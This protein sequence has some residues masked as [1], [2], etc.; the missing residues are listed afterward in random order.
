MSVKIQIAGADFSSYI[1]SCD[2]ID[3]I[4]RNRDWSPIF[5]TFQMS[6]MKNIPSIPSEGDNIL[7]IV[8]DVI[9][10][11]GYLSRI[12]Y[13]EKN[14]TYECEVSHYLRKLQSLK[15]SYDDIHETLVGGIADFDS[16]EVFSVDTGND[17]IQNTA[18]GR[19]DGD[20]IQ[21][22][23]VGGILPAGILE[24]HIYWIRVVDA[25][26]FRIYEDFADYMAYTAD[27]SSLNRYVDITG[28]G[29]GT[30]TYTAAL[31]L[32]SYNDWCYFR[33]IRCI[34]NTITSE[35]RL[36]VFLKEGISTFPFL[37]SSDSFNIVMFD[38]EISSLPAPISKSRAY[39]AAAQTGVSDID[40]FTIYNDLTDLGSESPINYSGTPSSSRPH[41]CILIRKVG[42]SEEQKYPFPIVSLKYIVTKIFEL[43][44]VN[45][46]TDNID[47]QIIC[48]DIDNSIEYGWDK[49][50]LNENMFYNL[51][52]GE[53][54]QPGDVNYYDQI[55]CLE[56]I[57][58]LFGKLGIAPK[59]TGTNG[60]PEYTFYSQ[61]RDINGIPDLDNEEEF[62][63]NDDGVLDYDNDN[64]FADEGGYVFSRNLTRPGG[65]GN[66]VKQGWVIECLSFFYNDP[67]HWNEDYSL[68]E[69]NNGSVSYEQRGTKAQ[70][71]SVPWFDNLIFFL[72]DTDE[73]NGTHD[74][75][76][77]KINRSLN[78]VHEEFLFPNSITPTSPYLNFYN[79]VNWDWISEKI[80]CKA[81]NLS[82]EIWRQK[83]I[84]LDVE[85]EEIKII[86]EQTDV[87]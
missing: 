8:D 82:Q 78:F 20:R 81:L 86:Q 63:I 74:V 54:S 23:S 49:I 5:G 2:D 62:N 47:S 42:E 43:I 45:I 24:K 11:L 44:G 34:V 61:T 9:Q 31:D 76:M 48:N 83:E 28:S 26:N 3:I 29:S 40:G 65:G 52:Q 60:F 22:R 7:L 85:K 66:L 27:N 79:S 36:G 57:I 67:K 50:Y 1:Y 59:F 64:I 72:K 84:S 18:H 53:T 75:R 55:S 87:F 14:Y 73:V 77:L 16:E 56:F 38:D 17:Y 30:L 21:F 69:G 37:L 32:D 25:D 15:V 68:S 58:D 80:I 33:D 46:N 19:S 12:K 70:L 71:N 41:F 39:A 4:S 35:V 51:N 10:Y 6:L 13:I